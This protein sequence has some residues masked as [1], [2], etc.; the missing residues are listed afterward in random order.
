MQ[1]RLLICIVCLMMVIV[2]ACGGASQQ[3]SSDTAQESSKDDTEDNK[4]SADVK[5]EAEPASDRGGHDAVCDRRGSRT[6]AAGGAER[7]PRGSGS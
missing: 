3:G 6:P 4:D 7:L 5:A 1:H 2:T